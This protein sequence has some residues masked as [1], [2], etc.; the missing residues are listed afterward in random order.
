MGRFALMTVGWETVLFDILRLGFAYLLALP[1]GWNRER[2]ER[3]AGVRTFPIV[4]VAACG[5]A[6]IG[7]AIPNASPDS[8]SRILQGLI[9]GIGFV[10]GG[11]ILRDKEHGDCGQHLEYRNRRSGCGI[12]FVP[13]CRD[14]DGDQLDHAKVPDTDQ[15]S[16][17][18][19]TAGSSRRLARVKKLLRS[20][21]DRR[22]S[23]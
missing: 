9:T 18:F 7:T 17:R 10:G 11:A 4:S 12:G 21:F 2:E 23:S 20:R 22:R 3:S 1:I 16:D 5:F 19:R 14:F 13:Y 8:Y 15:A 6:M